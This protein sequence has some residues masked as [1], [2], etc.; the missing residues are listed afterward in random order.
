MKQKLPTRRMREHPDLEQLKRQARELLRGFVAG[1]AEA[2]GEVYA[3]YHAPDRSKF[4]LHD[5]QLVIARSYGFESWPKLKAYVDGV[6]V[7]R[8]ADAVRTDDLAKVRAMLKARPELAD[9]AMSYVDEHRPIHFAVMKRSPEMVRLLMR[10]GANA[11]QGIHPHRDATTAWTIAKERGYDEIV[12]IIEEEEHR[13]SAPQCAPKTEVLGDEAA[14]AAVAAGDIVWLRAR[15]AEGTLV[16]P[17]RWNGGGLLTVAVRH[18]QP[19]LLR[20]M[21]DFGFDPDEK[22]SSG[23]GDWVAY[24]QGYPLWQCAALGR[25]EM[26][27]LLLERGANP[28]VHVDSSGSS[29]HS[30]YSHKQWDMVEFLRRHGGV[31]SAD[32]AAIYRQTDL[33]RQMLADEARGTL[34]EGIVSPG[35]PVAEDLLHFG[36]SGGDPEIVRMALE[37]IN[38]PRN[39]PRWFGS[40]TEPLYFWHHIPWLYAGN[41]EFDRA[42]Y[43]LCFRL[44]LERCGPNLIG[45]FGRTVL[46]EVAAMREHISDDEVTPFATALL[47][48]G[49]RVDIRDDL[50]KSTP[51]GWAC[52]WGRIELVKLLLERGAD[53]VEADAES[54]A[55][56]QAWAQRMG[57]EA[58]LAAL[59]GQSS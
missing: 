16:N 24:S 41:R 10:H 14:R 45:S 11:R 19:D 13:R 2:V 15:H 52:R 22:V 23:E 53:P 26:A 40:L 56:P 43:L 44:I 9:L 37:Q 12:A 20:L 4:A 7:Q 58:V 36:A 3:H 54:W 50:L 31:V 30:A 8:V 51:L 27:E 59:R 48:A 42:T 46:H 39:D 5:A 6:T 28:N 33:A 57:N 47:D 34:P 32:T 25:R 55:T 21:L 1:E 18:T 49:A 17:I 29:V 38:W 35:K